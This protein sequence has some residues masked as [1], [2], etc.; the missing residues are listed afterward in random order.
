MASSVITV[1]D[2][3]CTKPGGLNI[4]ELGRGCDH[5]G[6]L[7]LNRCGRDIKQI[8][9]VIWKQIRRVTHFGTIEYFENV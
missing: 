5:L 9:R 6:A 7:A 8:F 2:I 3:Q 1:T 4:R